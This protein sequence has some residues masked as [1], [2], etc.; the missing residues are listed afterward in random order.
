MLA[1]VG[2]KHVVDYSMVHSHNGR[3]VVPETVGHLIQQWRQKLI[4]RM[5]IFQL[6][7]RRM[8]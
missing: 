7:M 5:I 2:I 6:R 3:L 4:R 8:A 1:T